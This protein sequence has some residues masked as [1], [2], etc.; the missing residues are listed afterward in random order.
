MRGHL[1]VGIVLES[2]A[3]RAAVVTYRNGAAAIVEVIGA[4]STGALLPYQAVAVDELDNLAVVGHI[5]QAAELIDSVVGEGSDL[6][7]SL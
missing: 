4:E 3:H 2:V 7:V 5:D 1:T 6:I